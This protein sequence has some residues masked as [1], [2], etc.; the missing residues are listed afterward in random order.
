MSCSPYGS[1]NLFLAVSNGVDVFICFGSCQASL[2]CAHLSYFAL[3]WSKLRVKSPFLEVPAG[4]TTPHNPGDEVSLLYPQLALF[5]KMFS[6][7]PEPWPQ[8]VLL[9]AIQDLSVSWSCQFCQFT[10]STLQL[11][12]ILKKKI[13]DNLSQEKKPNKQTMMRDKECFWKIVTV[14]N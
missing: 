1:I 3:Q 2:P 13:H 10:S 8:I 5:I 12:Y 4:K 9:R 7:A 11:L 14:G 6:K